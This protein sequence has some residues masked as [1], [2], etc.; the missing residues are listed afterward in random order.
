MIDANKLVKGDLVIGS[1]SSDFQQPERQY[2]FLELLPTSVKL[3]DRKKG[4]VITQ[5]LNYFENHFSKEYEWCD[6]RKLSSTGGEY[7]TNRKDVEYR[8]DGVKVKASCHDD[9]TFDLDYGLALCLN[10]WQAKKDT[11]DAMKDANHRDL[12]AKVFGDFKATIRHGTD[13]GGNTIWMLKSTNDDTVKYLT[14]PQI[15]DPK[16][17]LRSD[18]T[19]KF[20]ED[21]KKVLEWIS[22]HPYT[23][24]GPS[25]SS[26]RFVPL[27]D[28]DKNEKADEYTEGIVT[29]VDIHKD[30]LDFPCYYH[31][32]HCIPADLTF[33]GE[34]AKRINEK[35]DMQSKIEDYIIDSYFT[36]ETILIENVFNLLANERKFAKVSFDNLKECVTDMA[37]AC[38]SF[39]IKYL[40]MPRIGCGHND[41]D[42]EKVRPMIIDT[43]NEV[44]KTINND[45]KEEN[46]YELSYHI[47]ISFCYQ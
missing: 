14:A 17:D 43:F 6:W 29:A 7:R 18:Y 5:S 45:F 34:T 20:E 2:I 22:C 44:Y 39:N 1:K 21:K 3:R 11:V 32:A 13:S 31:I 9:D 38:I 37:Y 25:T 10:K 47:N 15:F 42:W 12:T 4:W 35:W 23:D 24:P 19:K 16:T 40:A 30:L 36:G 28:E 46:G 33:W 27:D 8:K 41:L 26:E